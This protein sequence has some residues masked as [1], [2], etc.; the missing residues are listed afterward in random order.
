MTY[1]KNSFINILDFLKDTDRYFKNVA[2][3]HG[4]ILALV[5]P[6]LTWITR[7]ILSSGQI[8]YI[9]YDNINSILQGPRELLFA[10]V[11]VALLI[12]IIVFFEFTFLLLSIYFIRMK[13]QVSLK[14]LLWMTGIQ[15]KKVRASTILFFL[16]Y[17]FLILPLGGLGAHS[18][19]LAKIKIPAFIMDFVFANRVYVIATVLIFYLFLLYIGIRLIFALPK[20][21]LQD[22]N[23][24]TA[25]IKS[26]QRTQG[27]FFSILGQFIFIGGTV[28]ILFTIS[29]ILIVQLQKLIEVHAYKYALPSAVFFMTLLQVISIGNMVLSTAAI[30]YIIIDYMDDYGF[31]PEIPYWFYQEFSNNKQ[32]FGKVFFFL[33]TVL[34]AVG[35]GFYNVNYLTS[36]NT[37]TPLT[38][39]HRGV[40]DKNGVQNT[41]PALE[42]TVKDYT[43]E[44]VEMDVQETKDHQFVVMH[45]FNLRTLTGVNKTP[46]ELTLRELT[47]L[48]AKENNQTAKIPSFDEYLNEANKLDQHLLIELKTEEKDNTEMVQR[49]LDRYQKRILAEHH[50]LQ[51]MD[52]DIVE[53]IKKAAPQIETGYILP[54]NVVGPPKSSA[55][56]LTMEYSTINQDF[57][58]AAKNDGKKVYVWTV[59]REDAMSRMQFYGADGIIT[60]RM[61]LLNKALFKTKEMTY[62]DKLAHFVIGIG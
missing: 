54:F 46:K 22:A 17:F 50:Q 31:L 16:F 45:D 35:A 14:Q 59:N 1:I 26:W 56:F 12:L 36:A 52:H 42:K 4:F 40:S 34:L 23:F 37:S 39:S 48:T 19:L 5:I 38:I 6:F 28:L 25:V 41:L 29:T 20:M 7:W 10:L 60:D 61:D 32:K 2:L 57:I 13:K 49:F 18:D 55:D 11:L 47:K 51:C 30:F 27:H 15:L 3:M 21:I 44:Y 9:S 53:Q 43:P 8:D 62:S 58:D 33:I 24:Q